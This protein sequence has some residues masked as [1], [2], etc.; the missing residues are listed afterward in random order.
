MAITIVTRAVKG[1]KI[2]ATEFDANFNNLAAAIENITT[3]TEIIT[4]TGDL[5]YTYPGGM[6]KILFLNPNGSG[7]NVN[8]MQTP[9][10]YP[11]GFE[12]VC[13]NYGPYVIVLDSAGSAIAVPPGPGKSIYFDGTNWYE[14]S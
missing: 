11:V 12:I 3:I 13:F 8:F 6:K 7:R 4:M 10:A 14:H 2:N 9:T 5:A 1:A